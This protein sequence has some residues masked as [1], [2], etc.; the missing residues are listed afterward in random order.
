MLDSVF[1]E[2]ARARKWVLSDL[3]DHSPCN[4]NTVASRSTL[5]CAVNR[6]LAVRIDRL[7]KD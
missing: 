4:F 1:G 7:A 3:N 5:H 2:K 6:D